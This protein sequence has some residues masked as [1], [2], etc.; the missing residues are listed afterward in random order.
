FTLSHALKGT[1]HAFSL[2]PEGMRKLVRDLKRAPAAL[3]DG[4][5]RR[6]PSEEG[7]LRKMGKN[8]VAGRALPAGHVLAAEDLSIKSPSEGG[9]PPYELDTLV[10]RRLTRALAEEEPV[11]P[12]ALEPVAAH[13]AVAAKSA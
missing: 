5:K 6:Y 10:G 11:T 7:P 1:D 2:M 3:G 13:D 4:V 12:A 9:L 8:L